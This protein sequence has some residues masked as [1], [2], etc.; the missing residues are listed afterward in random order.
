MKQ[1]KKAV[2]T[3]L[4]IYSASAGVSMQETVKR[5]REQDSTKECIMM[6][7]LA[8]ADPKM[9]REIGSTLPKRT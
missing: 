3:A 5:Y 2:K 9:L 7:V 8:Q 4:E 6:L 1:F